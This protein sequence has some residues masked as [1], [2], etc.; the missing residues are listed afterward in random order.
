MQLVIDDPAA[1]ERD[2]VRRVLLC[3]GKL[4]YSLAA[5]RD[6]EGVKDAAIVRVEQLY[7][8]PKRELQQILAKYRQAR[9]FAWVQEEPKNRGAWTFMADRL[10]AMLPDPA[11]LTYFGRDEA[12][13]PAT[14]SFKMHDIEEKE[15]IAHALELAPKEPAAAPAMAGSLGAPAAG[16]AVSGN[17]NGAAAGPETKEAKPPPIPQPVPAGVATNNG[18]GANG[19]NGLTGIAAGAPATAGSQT[20]VS[21]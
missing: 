18:N 4:Y 15:I 10:R 14:G 21:D 9:E 12:A 19:Q 16:G 5:A 7:P 20:P 17:G 2:K 6:K 1:P 11:V 8:Y 13:S 3:S